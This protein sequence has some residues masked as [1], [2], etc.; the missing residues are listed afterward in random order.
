M[1]AGRAAAFLITNGESAAFHGQRLRRRIA[2]FDPDT[3]SR[4]LAGALL[5]AHWV[6]QAQ[7]VRRWWLD[8]MMEVFR[9]VDLILAPATPTVAPPIGAKTLTLG[10]TDVPLRP[11]L[12]ALAQP[13]SCIGLPVAT[14][15]VF[16]PGDLP[17]GVQIIAPPWRED[18]CCRAARFLERRG[19]AVAHAPPRRSGDN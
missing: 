17:I 3:R 18:L 15:P 10:N 5:P 6:I 11:N 16:D 8:R 14:V 1:A 12:G 9:S 13:F 7:R 2:D 4:F 19:V